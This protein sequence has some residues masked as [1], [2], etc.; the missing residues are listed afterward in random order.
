MKSGPGFVFEAQTRGGCDFQ[1]KRSLTCSSMNT[2]LTPSACLFSLPKKT[3]AMQKRPLVGWVGGLLPSYTGIIR[4]HYKD[5]GSL[6]NNQ[7]SME[8]TGPREW[9]MFL[10]ESCFE[11]SRRIS[12]PHTSLQ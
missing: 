6:L 9:V 2:L 1:K 3:L 8:S 5:P 10:F 7:D 12:H 4:N 11:A